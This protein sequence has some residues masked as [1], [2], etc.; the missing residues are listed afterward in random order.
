MLNEFCVLS[1]KSSIR[2]VGA[3]GYVVI[4]AP[5]PTYDYADLPNA[6]IAVTLAYTLEPQGKLYGALLN[7]TTGI[8]HDVLT[9]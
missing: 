8:V 5:C 2:L 3:S 7:V 9:D 6:L 1:D 4:I